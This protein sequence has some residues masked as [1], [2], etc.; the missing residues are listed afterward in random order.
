MTITIEITV[1]DVMLEVDCTE[2]AAEAFLSDRSVQLKCAAESAIG[3]EIQEIFCYW[4]D[5]Q[6]ESAKDS[7]IQHKID[8]IRG[9]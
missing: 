8:V 4:E 1:D 9:K 6:I 7:A 2:K 3:E 5:D